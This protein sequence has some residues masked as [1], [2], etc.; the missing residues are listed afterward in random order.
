MPIRLNAE[1]VA[2]LEEVARLLEEQEANEFRV[3]AYRRAAVLLREL[4]RPVDA[5]IEK[6]GIE[7]LMRLPGVG[8]SQ[9]R[10]IH[11]LAVTGALPML[12]QLRGESDPVTV[13]ESVPGVGRVL[14]D[15]LH[16]ELGIAS[17]EELEAAAHDGRL[18][19]IVGVG[20]KRIA[21][22]RDS[23]AYRLGRPGRI[24]RR[25]NLPRLPDEPAVH[26]LLDAGRTGA[27][28]R[29]ALDVSR[30]LERAGSLSQM[31]RRWLVSDG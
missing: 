22:I 19:E 13:L 15:R 2:R 29:M 26:E 31:L 7:G 6:E 4:E 10:S 8:H 16:S 27:V 25:I 3:N 5:L 18:A 20:E 1:I 12:E 30:V 9:A 11:Q 21:G 23:L 24:S 17:L 28:R 14:A